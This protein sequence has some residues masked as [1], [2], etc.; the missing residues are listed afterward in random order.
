MTHIYIY[1]YIYIYIGSQQS[2]AIGVNEVKTIP[3]VDTEPSEAAFG[4]KQI[5]KGVGFAEYAF[6]ANPLSSVSGDGNNLS[7]PPDFTTKNSE[8]ESQDS[9]SKLFS[10]DALE[11][12]GGDFSRSLNVSDNLIAECNKTF[13]LGQILGFSMEGYK[14]SLKKIIKKTGD[15]NGQS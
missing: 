8:E 12:Q 2:D 1:I 14:E 13:E 6:G 10:R 11:L 5:S 9:F 3:A 4:A 15:S 7:H